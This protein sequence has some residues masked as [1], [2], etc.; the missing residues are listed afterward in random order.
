MYYK[1]EWIDGILY[2]KSSPDGEW[3]SF[4]MQQY[5]DKCLKLESEVRRL[6]QLLQEAGKL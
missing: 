2:W 3:H 6:K 5:K 4:T 1:E